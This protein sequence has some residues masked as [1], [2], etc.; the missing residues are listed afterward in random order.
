MGRD[1]INES[2]HINIKTTLKYKK[3]RKHKEDQQK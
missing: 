3:E 1:S 2:D